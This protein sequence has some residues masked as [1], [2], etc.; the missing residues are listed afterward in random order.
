MH[1]L[2]PH[3]SS[4]RNTYPRIAQPPEHPPAGEE[5]EQHHPTKPYTTNEQPSAFTTTTI[6]SDTTTV[7]RSVPSGFQCQ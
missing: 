5:L 7:G 4:T 1:E 3:A 6:S 2:T